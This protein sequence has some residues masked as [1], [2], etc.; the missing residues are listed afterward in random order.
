V[1][2]PA[3]VPELKGGEAEQNRFQ[4]VKAIIPQA[5][6]PLNKQEP[7]HPPPPSPG[8]SLR[9]TS[10]LDH[11]INLFRCS[12][13]QRK[14]KMDSL[15]PCMQSPLCSPAYLNNEA[16]LGLRGYGMPVFWGYGD[17]PP[18]ASDHHTLA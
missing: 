2:E 3:K 5:L 11:S 13:G 8:P 16:Q 18:M 12:G 9:S 4:M 15:F 17:L 7:P 10:L 1:S 6:F 14:G